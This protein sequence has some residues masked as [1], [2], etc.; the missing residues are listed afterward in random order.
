MTCLEPPVK[1]TKRE[2][3]RY[4]VELKECIRLAEANPDSAIRRLAALSEVDLAAFKSL[5]DANKRRLTKGNPDAARYL[6]A[7]IA[8]AQEARRQ[9]EHGQSIAEAAEEGKDQFYRENSQVRG[10]KIGSVAVVTYPSQGTKVLPSA[11]TRRP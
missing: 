4:D 9:A 11:K 10:A 5:W 6:D 2:K 1:L 8:K 7:S 3:R